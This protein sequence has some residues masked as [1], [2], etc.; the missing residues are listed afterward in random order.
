VVNCANLYRKDLATIDRALSAGQRSALLIVKT[1]DG[2]VMIS[3]HDPFWRDALK[4][5]HPH[6][7]ALIRREDDFSDLSD[8]TAGATV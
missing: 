6:I 1:D 5:F 3:L 8:R 4:A 2:V 7:Q